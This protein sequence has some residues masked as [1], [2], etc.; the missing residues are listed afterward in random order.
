MAMKQGGKYLII[1]I[2]QI[3][4]V[5]SNATTLILFVMNCYKT[6]MYLSCHIYAN[7]GINAFVPTFDWHERFHA[8][9]GINVA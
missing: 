2:F 5:E 1:H 6:S 4:Y 7:T 3:V 9:V 8:N